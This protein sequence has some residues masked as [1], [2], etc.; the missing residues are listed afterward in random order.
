[1]RIGSEFHD[2]PP[3]GFLPSPEP[4]EEPEGGRQPL[5][6]HHG[7]GQIDLDGYVGQTSPDGSSKSMLGFA[8]AVLSLDSPPVPLVLLLRLLITTG[9]LSP[10][11]KQCR[12][13]I[14]DEH[15][16]GLFPW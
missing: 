2:E 5:Q 14:H 1:M 11:P 9:P 13:V 7:G 8:D 3:L 16:P 4:Q 6:I 10:R 15:R 12:V